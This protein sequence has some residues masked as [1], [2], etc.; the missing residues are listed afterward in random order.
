MS[1][2]PLYLPVARDDE[3]DL[4]ELYRG[5][6]LIRNHLPHLGPPQGPRHE[7]SVGSQGGVLSYQ[8][9]LP[10]ARDDDAD[11]LELPGGLG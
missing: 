10:V 7:P 9:Y 8:M 1:E 6:W 3:A 11:L 5:S 4:A 2:V